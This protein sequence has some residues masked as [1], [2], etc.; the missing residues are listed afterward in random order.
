MATMVENPFDTTQKAGATD[1][2]TTAPST[3]AGAT[4]PD[5]TTK[6]AGTGLVSSNMAGGTSYT[7]KAPEANTVSQYDAVTRTVDPTTQTVQGQVESILSKDSPL[8]QRA[9]TLATQQMAQR[10]LVNSSM[11]AGAGT[12]A[13]IDKATPIAAQDANTYSTAASENMAA[14]NQNLQFNLGEQN[15]FSLQG[16]QQAFTASQSEL[17]RS[18]QTNL[19]KAQQDFT[20]AQNEVDRAQQ[21]YL[22]DRSFANQ[23]ALQKSQ[24][25][26]TAAQSE[27]DRSQQA[28]MQDDVQAFQERMRNTEIPANFAM[29]I[30]SS[31]AQSVN[32]IAADANLSGTVDGYYDK[33]GKFISTTTIPSGFVGSSPKTRAIQST[34][35]YA[36]AQVSWANKF[37]S[38]TIPELPSS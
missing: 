35:N 1:A 36:N 18:Q 20:A 9:R 12:A 31:L 14:R 29:A 21:V 23:E 17:D 11:A 3:T 28:Y 7:T 2:T 10:G 38:T 25:N 16:G 24:Q 15:R 6:S 32:A 5:S 27:L 13:M 22:Q 37:Y 34:I 30:S 19:Q 33:D 8:M 26:F 4:A